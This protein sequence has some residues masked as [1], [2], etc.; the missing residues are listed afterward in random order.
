MRAI[1][2]RLAA[3]MVAL[4][5]VVGSAAQDNAG[6]AILFVWNDVLYAQSTATNELV[7]TEVRADAVPVAER[8]GNVFRH[9]E[10]PLQ[11][12][13]LDGYGFVQGVWS[14]DGT[15]FA[16]LAIEPETAHYR[17]VSI[18]NGQQTLLV[19]GEV[20]PERGYLVPAGWGADGALILLERYGLHTIDEIRLWQY[21][22]EDDLALWISARVPGLKGNS[23]A[24]PGGWVFVGFDTIGMQAYLVSTVTGQ[25]LTTNTA[26]ALQPP[27]SVF[28][29][30]PVDVVGVV[31]M[32]EFKAWHAQQ[33]P[34]ASDDPATG[35][36]TA[37]F[38]HW[39]LPD[40]LRSITCYPDSA[41]TDAHY[42]LECPGLATPR[43][44]QGHEGTDVGGKPDGLAVGTYIYA[45]APGLALAVNT[46]CGS[47]DTSCGD[48]YGNYV[49]LEHS[50]MD[51]ADIATWFTGYAHLE[52]VLI[53][54][55]VYVE[56]IGIPVALSGQSG[57][58]GPHL[59]F[60][61]RAPHQAARTNWI[62]PWDLAQS[63]DGESLWVGGVSRPL[64]AVVAFP[65]PTLMTCETQAGNN[66]RRGP[67]TDYDIVAKSEAGT[68]YSVFQVQAVQ[69]GGTPGDWYHVRWGESM[70]GWI[71]AELMPDCT[72]VS[73]E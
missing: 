46:G 12:I 35:W 33:P 43:A 51:G 29:V 25:V 68:A 48:A 66:I 24:L 44:Y 70:S 64:A 53:E 73:T 6:H 34:Q 15:V 27:P 45:A 57:L 59:H 55:N 67:G 5:G 58:G 13:P 50:R 56:E 21:R 11:D 23:A 36:T 26:F 38:L 69:S 1:V 7:R 17:V 20:G 49:L 71:Y 42:A 61:V 72:R 47:E 37:P 3:L 40:D 63:P 2:L 19:A 8:G 9:D 62:D 65:P 60:E 14:P 32:A 52:T 18:E 31:S 41:W 4:L 10:S 22:S 54:P 28:E 39:P 16:F 30:Y